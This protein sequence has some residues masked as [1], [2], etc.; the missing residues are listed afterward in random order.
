MTL[1]YIL[2]IVIFEPFWTLPTKR[3]RNKTAK[4]QIKVSMSYIH[5]ILKMLIIF[6]VIVLSMFM[7]WAFLESQ[8]ALGSIPAPLH[9]AVIFGLISSMYFMLR[10]VI[11]GLMQEAGFII[12]RLLPDSPSGRRAIKKPVI[13]VTVFHSKVCCLVCAILMV[14]SLIDR[15]YYGIESPAWLLIVPAILAVIAIRM[16]RSFRMKNSLSLGIFFSVFAWLLVVGY[17]QAYLEYIAPD[18]FFCLA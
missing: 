17:I 9:L 2:V 1:Y 12:N 3:S 14:C 6:I 4:K 16:V 5:I 8:P 15:D 18:S 10:K 7:Y 11:R 13:W